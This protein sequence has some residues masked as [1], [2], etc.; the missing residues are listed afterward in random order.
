MPI[1]NIIIDMKSLLQI[2]PDK[3]DEAFQR[4]GA[5]RFY[6]IYQKGRKKEFFD[7]F[8]KGQ[9]NA[10]TFCNDLRKELELA[11]VQDDQDIENAWNAMLVGTNQTRIDQLKILSEKYNVILFCDTNEIHYEA[12]QDLFKQ[13]TWECL[14]KFCTSIVRS[15][16]IGAT[17]PDAVT[18]S[19]LLT[20]H[21]IEAEETL[22]L[23]NS[24]DNI[25]TARGLGSPTLPLTSYTTIADIQRTINKFNGSHNEAKHHHVAVAR[26]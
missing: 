12:S 14:E 20:D 13:N 11:E 24:F 21:K 26:L 10:K 25:V 9:I 18:Y 3:T 22:F 4:L 7:Q 19:L 15:D 16:K 2:D 23:S 8:N 17:M 6:E 1:K 5:F